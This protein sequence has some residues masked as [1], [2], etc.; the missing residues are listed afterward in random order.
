MIKG[1]IL[2]LLSGFLSA[3]SQVLLKKS[4]V[5]ER[6]SVIKEYLNPLVISGYALTGCCMVLMIFAYKY[7]PLKYGAV[8]ESLVYI[9]ALIL[10]KMVF[11]EKIT[12]T[13]L[14]GTLLIVA[15]VIV[16]S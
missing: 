3:F 1:V 8:F 14:L 6:D 9:Y 5:I 7:L 4:A 13:Q 11:D 16:F 2:A 10:G 12:R 15:G